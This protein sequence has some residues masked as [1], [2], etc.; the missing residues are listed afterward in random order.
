M[1][2]DEKDL[3]LAVQ[4]PPKELESSRMETETPGETPQGQSSES[5]DPLHTY[6]WQTGSRGTL[7][8]VK[9]EGQGEVASSTSTISKFQKAS[10][11]KW[12][13]MQ[14][15]RKALSEDPGDKNPSNGKGG[16][17][18]KAD[19]SS[20]GSKRNLFRRA[21][22]EPPGSLAARVAQSTVSTSTASCAPTGASSATAEDPG[23]SSSDSSHRGGGGML[24]KKYLRTVSQK[25]KRP[26]LMSRSSNPNMMPG[27]AIDC[28]HAAVKGLLIVF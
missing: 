21:Q 16:E 22:S 20:A 18:G 23:V 8:E 12:N 3:E 19:K 5:A 13:K 9:E 17:G 26:R 24:F 4:D 10:A 15:W 1:G 28:H 7:N 11:N 2:T 6:K 14:N 25:F 27:T